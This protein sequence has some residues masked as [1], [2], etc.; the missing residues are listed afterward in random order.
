MS[1]STTATVICYLTDC[2]IPADEA[3]RLTLTDGEGIHAESLQVFA[4]RE[5]L[6]FQADRGLIERTD[7]GF[8]A[9]V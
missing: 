6:E 3:A 2:P 5:A 1:A 8:V 7:Q 9:V 4:M